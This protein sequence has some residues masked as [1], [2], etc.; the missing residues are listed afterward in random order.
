MDDR[1]KI[2]EFLEKKAIED[3]KPVSGFPDPDIGKEPSIFDIAYKAKKK[4]I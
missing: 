2:R 4:K 3:I 1:K